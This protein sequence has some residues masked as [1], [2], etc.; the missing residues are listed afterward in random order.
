M[1]GFSLGLELLPV[2]RPC[3]RRVDLDKA[4]P[5]IERSVPGEIP[6]GR[7]CHRPRSRALGMKDRRIDQPC[8]QPLPLMRLSDRDLGNVEESIQLKGGKKSDRLTP[9]VGSHPQS[10]VPT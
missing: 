1:S 10:S 6:I 5:G 8:A 7:E 3:L 9:F 2:F 4:E